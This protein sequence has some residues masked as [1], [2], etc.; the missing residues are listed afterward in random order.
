[1]LTQDPAADERIVKG[2]TI[3]LT[4]SLGPERYPVPD[5]TGME[6]AAAKGELEQVKLK[7]KEGKGQYSDTVPRG[8]GD[9]HRPEGGHLAEA[10]RARSPWWSARAARR[11]PCPT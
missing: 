3:T 6:L 10:R 9:L 4:L 1:M 5:V 7:L 8:R 11:S 2:G